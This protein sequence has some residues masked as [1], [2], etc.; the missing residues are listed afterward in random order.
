[1]ERGQDVTSAQGSSSKC[2]QK[3]RRRGWGWSVMPMS[4]FRHSFM[5]TFLPSR[6]S[7][8]ACPVRTWKSGSEE[9]EPDLPA[10]RDHLSMGHP[11]NWLLQLQPQDGEPLARAL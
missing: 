8:N 10:G 4:K 3:V 5:N 6:T 2:R 7:M 11:G 9:D 1:M